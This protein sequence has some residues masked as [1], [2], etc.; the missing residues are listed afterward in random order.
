MEL[1][2]LILEDCSDLAVIHPS[3]SNL[4]KL[5]SLNV[6]QCSDLRELP[7]L[8]PMRGLKELLID[9]TSLPYLKSLKYLALDGTGIVTLGESIGSLEKLK[10]LS[11]KDCRGLSN[12][13]DDI[14]KLRS[15]QFLDLSNTLIRELPPSVKNL[16]DMKVLRMRD[17]SIRE[18]PEDILNLEK[19][20]EIDFTSCRSLA[21]K[22][23]DDIGRLSSLAILKLSDTRIS[24]QLPPSISRLS[25]LREIRISRCD[26][27]QKD[28][29]FRTEEIQKK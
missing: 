15:L 11:L 25:R 6:K 13:P 5:V 3:F 8:G 4:K 29:W 26:N 28:D 9:Q 16:K 12:L 17:T 20:E 21:G 24:G 1:E 23:P 19:L 14:G 2:R 22:I 7:D 10:T 27:L 18:F